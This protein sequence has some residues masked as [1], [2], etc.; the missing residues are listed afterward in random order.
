MIRVAN[1][2]SGN[3]LNS[4]LKP[5]TLSIPFL[6]LPLVTHLPLT[7]KGPKHFIKPLY[8]AASAA[9]AP[10]KKISCST[11]FKYA[12]VGSFITSSLF[13][14]TLALISLATLPWTVLISGAY[15]LTPQ[16]IL[17]RLVV[18]SL[19][20]RS[21]SS[22]DPWALLSWKFWWPANI[23]LAA[24]LPRFHFA[25]QSFLIKS[26]KSAFP[27]VAISAMLRFSGQCYCCPWLSLVLFRYSYAPQP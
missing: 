6:N 3:K 18:Y 9:M 22:S 25:I 26:F 8:T 12:A 1:L 21:C 24:L 14:F 13:L 20:W 5:K 7:H 27:F 15:P 19:H 10:A 23:L 2:Q 11:S 17:P 16:F 4:L